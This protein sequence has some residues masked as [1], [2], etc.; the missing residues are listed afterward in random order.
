MS[1]KSNEVNSLAQT[2]GNADKNSPSEKAL[3]L[4]ERCRKL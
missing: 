4:H 2:Y 1:G 3:D